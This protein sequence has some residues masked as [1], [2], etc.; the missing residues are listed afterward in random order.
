MYRKDLITSEIQKLAEV[1][2]RIMGLKLEGKLKDAQEIFNETMENSFTL[3][4]DILESEEHTTFE[5]W[6][7]KCDFPPEKLDSLSEFLYYELGISTERNQIIAPKLNLVYQYLADQHKIVH[8][9]N[10]H[11]QKTIQQYI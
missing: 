1:L 2:A 5:T 7:E 10:L 8:L 3:P 11:R 4:I 6:L 9:V